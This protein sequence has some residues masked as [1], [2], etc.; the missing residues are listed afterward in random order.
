MDV[1]HWRFVGLD[2]YNGFS[3]ASFEVRLTE[4]VFL[5]TRISRHYKYGAFC[6]AS[7]SCDQN[8]TSG[9]GDLL[10]FTNTVVS[11]VQLFWMDVDLEAFGSSSCF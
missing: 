8:S 9:T 4:I 2:K 5:A 6:F 3:L 1:R 7:L 10:G 11:G